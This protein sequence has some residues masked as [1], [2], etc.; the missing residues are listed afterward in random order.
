MAYTVS[1]GYWDW[2]PW[3][4]GEGDNRLWKGVMEPSGSTTSCPAY[5][6]I[7]SDSVID[8]KEDRDP[9]VSKVSDDL[10]WTVTLKDSADG[11]ECLY[12]PWPK[13]TTGQA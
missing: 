5:I 11:G 3:K 12:T 10:T 7:I 13:T 1:D 8:N 4:H 6:S 9:F 2:S